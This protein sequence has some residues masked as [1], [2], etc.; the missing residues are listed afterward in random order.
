MILLFSG[1]T[2]NG[3]EKIAIDVNKEEEAISIS[4]PPFQIKKD[5]G[6]LHISINNVS[7]YLME[8]GKPMLPKIVRVFE[9]PFKARNIRIN[10]TVDN[11]EEYNIEGKIAPS[12]TAMPLS[13]PYFINV[14][15][16]IYESEKLYPATWYKFR[17]GCGLNSYCKRVTYVT[18]HLF[19]VRYIPSKN[20][21]YFASNFNIKIDY[22]EPEEE[23]LQDIYDMVIIAPSKFADELQPLIEHKNEHG[24]KTMIKTTESIYEEYDGRDR[25]EQIKYFIK[26][27]IENYGIKYVLL[28]GGLKSPIWGKPRD[29]E[30]QG[31]NDWYVPVR[32]C[33]LYDHPKYPLGESIYDP[34]VIT[35]LY[36][37]DVYGKEGKFESWDPNGDGIFAAWGKPNVENDTGIDLYPDVCIGR[38]A[39]RNE[40][41]V[42]DVVDKIIQYE[43]NC[44]D[45]WFKRMVVISGDGFLDQQDLNIEWDTNGLPDGKYT[46]YA[47]SIND[48]GKKSFIDVIHVTIDRSKETKLTFTHDDHLNEA[49]KNGYP[50][51][52]IVEITSP[53][54]GDTLGYNDYFYEPSENEAYCNSF[55]G[56]ANVEYRNGIMHI[57]GKSYDPKP[58]GNITSIHIWI[59]DS[60]GNIIFS[61]WRNNTEMYYEGEWVTGEK[62]LK[63]RGGALYYMPDD[64]EK[65]ILWTSNG[66]F[67]SQND[68]IKALSK[69]AGFV[70]F[71]GHGSPM[72]WGDHFPG[73]PGNRRHGSV[74]GLMNVAIF[75]PFFPMN[76]LANYNKPFVC[77]VGGCH[78]CQFNVSLLATATDL[79]NKK[80]MWC[81]GMPVPEC[82][83]WWLTRLPE[84]GAIATIGNT[85]LG[86]GILGKDCTIGGVDGWITTEF[87]RQYGEEK[88]D[89]L[90]EAHAQTLISYINTFDMEALEEG[91]PK[92]VMQWVLL[93]DPSLKIGGYE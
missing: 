1:I 53:S 86:Y 54:D 13:M 10:V 41:E 39:C 82:W 66:K 74:T 8:A 77:I 11:I 80:K 50:A 23:N 43:N 64:F 60:N 90:G 89:I 62:L 4:S 3:Y 70:F 71:S 81:Y 42:K 14:T 87:F 67:S 9:I 51:P 61:A 2:Y 21:I 32:Y 68:V 73:I 47:Q 48:E 38:L 63:G 57:R 49:L 18:I 69:G 76:K 40:K 83:G 27:A 65:E 16:S 6:Y 25:P 91:H 34:G 55:T 20:K 44:H 30:N 35:D 45:S 58:Y 79:F 7:T 31:A 59:E 19:P 56:W 92:T 85:G 46:I 78:N 28:V 12:P 37:A 36:Y 52:P 24:I 22:D 84:R 15:N 72:S 88:H 93:G 5:G 75:P 26:D 17:I 33:N 29:D